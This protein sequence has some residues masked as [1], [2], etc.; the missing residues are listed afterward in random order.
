[1]NFDLPTKKNKLQN[2]QEETQKY[3]ILKKKDSD[4][5][6]FLVPINSLAIETQNF[7]LESIK[8]HKPITTK[9]TLQLSESSSQLNQK[10]ISVTDTRKKLANIATTQEK[11][12][13][14]KNWSKKKHQRPKLIS[15]T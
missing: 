15:S 9:T 4:K 8:N 13:K 2:V 5:P 1:M 3:V 14:K 6:P 10:T 12:D 11:K 7:L